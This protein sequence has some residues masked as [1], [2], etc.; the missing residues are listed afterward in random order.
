MV[1][2]GIHN[3]NVSV[4]RSYVGVVTVRVMPIVKEDVH[5]TI[6]LFPIF[7]PLAQRI[8][9]LRYG[10]RGWEFESLRDHNDG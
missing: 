4:V 5:A 6:F 7:G 10:R 9:A 1:D 2:W 3:V 8:R